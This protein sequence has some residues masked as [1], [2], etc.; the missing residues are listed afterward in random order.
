M[1]E[2]TKNIDI[3]FTAKVMFLCKSG[4]CDNKVKQGK[5]T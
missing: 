4:H 5:K 1:A 3:D 2:I